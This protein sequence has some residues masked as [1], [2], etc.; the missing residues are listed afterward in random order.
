MIQNRVR[1]LRSL[2]PRQ[3]WYLLVG[4]LISTAG[5]G[6]IWPFLTIYISERL[7]VSMTAVTSLLTIDSI[8][9]IISSF[10]AGSIADRFG[11]KWVLV[12][13]LV[14]MGIVYGLM[15]V[16]DTFLAFLVLMGLRGVVV[17][18]YRIGADAMVADLIPSERRMDA[19]SLLRMSNNVG[20]AVGPSLGGFVAAA[21]YGVAFA[22]AAACLIFFGVLVAL[23]MVETLPKHASGPAAQLA[24]SG[25]GPVLRDRFYL[26]YILGLTFTGMA[27]SLMFVLI[28]AYA[29]HNFNLLENETGVLMAV[30]ALM[31][32]LLQVLVTR[33]THRRSP[34]AMSALGALFYAFGV[35]SVALGSQLWHFAASM[36]FMTIGELILTPTSTTY[37]TNLAPVEMRARYL[38]I[39]SLGWGVSHGFGPVVGGYLNDQIAPVAIWYGG[40]GWGLLSALIFA[41]LLLRQ[42]AKQG[43]VSVS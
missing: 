35:G 9:S 25:Y 10:V 6:M 40:L 22:G 28:S 18:L 36:A 8:M 23:V 38:S 26:V 12:V 2:Y 20:V 39:Y 14:S 4:M 5:M 7:N 1:A 29:K 32:V 21:S 17:P 13:S 37:A 19:Y 24:T 31:V 34:L 3:Y 43:A 42:R 15:G 11:R 27:S 41:L 33:I 16:A 30:N